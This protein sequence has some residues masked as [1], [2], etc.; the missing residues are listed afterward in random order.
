MDLE[1][2]LEALEAEVKVL[3]SEIHNILLEIQE[4]VLLH[5]YPTLRVEDDEPSDTVIQALEEVR[6]KREEDAGEAESAADQPDRDLDPGSGDFSGLFKSP[7]M[8]L[9]QDRRAETSGGNGRR[10]PTLIP[11]PQM[12]TSRARPEAPRGVHGGEWETFSEMAAWVQE[13]INR[14]GAERTSQLIELYA[15]QG[16]LSTRAADGLVH[17]MALFV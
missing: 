2:R 9:G 12:A 8:S 17:L 11:P 6:R 5:Y 4:Q 14:I 13:S 16:I 3:K 15:E 7:G 10:H 1:V